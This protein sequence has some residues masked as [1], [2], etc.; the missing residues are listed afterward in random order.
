MPDF[1]EELR[2]DKCKVIWQM[3]EDGKTVIA[4][5]EYPGVLEKQSQRWLRSQ[6]EKIGVKVVVREPAA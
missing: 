5:T 6:F 3:T 2:P 4:L 1:P